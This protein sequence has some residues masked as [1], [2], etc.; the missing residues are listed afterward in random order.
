MKKLTISLSIITTILIFNGCGDGDGGDKNP[1]TTN[2]VTKPAIQESEDIKVDSS[3]DI[4]SYLFYGN[5]NH[6]KLASL[7]N[8]KVIDATNPDNI[9]VE[10]SNTTDIRLPQLSIDMNYDVVKNSYSDL[11]INAVGYTS[12]GQPKKVILKKADK[13]ALK[14]ISNSTA[15]NITAPSYK[16][17]DYLGTKYYLST[18]N[19]NGNSILI[20]TDMKESDSA[21]SFDNREFITIAYSSYGADVNGYI[22]YD[23][24]SKTIQNCSTDLTSCKDI[25]SVKTTKVSYGKESPNYYFYGDILTTTKS[26]IKVDNKLYR[27]DRADNSI[28]EI[29]NGADVSTNSHGGYKFHKDTIYFSTDGNLQKLNLLNNEVTTLSND[30]EAEKT[31]ALIN[32]WV[33]YGSDGSMFATKKD[34]SMADSPITLSI[35]TKTKGQKYPFDMGVGEQYLYNLYSVDS[36][37]GNVTYKACKFE[38]GKKECQNNYFWVGI[39]ASESGNL[40]FDS[41]YKYTPSK[42]LRVDTNDNYGGGVLKSV[43]PNSPFENGLSLGKVE[44]YNFQNFI[45]NSKYPLIDNSGDMIIYAKDDK[46]VKGD[47]FLVNINQKDS[48]KNLTNEVNANEDITNGD[49]HCHGRFC[50]VCH[51]FAGG[52]IYENKEGTKPAYGYNIRFDFENGDSLRARLG[53]GKGENFNT[54]IENIAGKNF[55]AVVVDSNGL[56]MSSSELYSHSGADYA[57]C[58]FCHDRT[59]DMRYGAPNVI[60]IEKK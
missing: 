51:S 52:K 38:N 6:K 55:T 28:V 5:T 9:L 37:S 60:T 44:F 10:N 30:G 20:T 57:N 26:A 54:P 14:E 12:N 33:I 29:T 11:H 18:K 4:E 17:I 41:S 46:N 40:N 19:E 16:S 43:N 45:H 56:E 13:D 8:L 50:F 27:V 2:T 31:L 25:I 53:K 7:I 48:L 23:E 39:T 22:I 35:N 34:G 3:K 15:T 1:S 21:L 36:D 32:D 59:G 47:A 42:Y 49:V 58:N 24:N